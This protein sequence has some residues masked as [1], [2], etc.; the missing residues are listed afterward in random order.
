MNYLAMKK[1]GA[2]PEARRPRIV[3]GPWTH[4]GR[5]SKLLRF[6]YGPTA[7]IDWNGYICRW[8]DYHLKGIA[9]GVRNDPPVQV[10]QYLI[11]F[12]RGTGNAFLK[13]HRIRIEISSSYYSLYLRNLNTGADNVG[14]ETSHVIAH[15]TIHHHATHP[16]HVILPVIPVRDSNRSP[17]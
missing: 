7:A 16:S 4:T 12:W 11:E 6:D 3:I 17:E 13:G 15:Q 9:N 14:L 8:F 2:T 1:Y 10:Y 5:G